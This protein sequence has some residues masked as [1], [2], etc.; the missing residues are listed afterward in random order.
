MEAGEYTADGPL[1]LGADAD[2]M[3]K[4]ARAPMSD[5]AVD[6]IDGEG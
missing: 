4:A 5:P 1:E 6:E 3:L 2:S